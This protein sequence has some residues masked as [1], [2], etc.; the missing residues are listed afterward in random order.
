MYSQ[1]RTAVKRKLKETLTPF[2]YSKWKDM[3]YKLENDVFILFSMKLSFSGLTCTIVTSVNVIPYCTVWD[4]LTESDFNAP[5]HPEHDSF[6]YEMLA[7]L[8]L[9]EFTQENYVAFAEYYLD[10]TTAMCE[11]ELFCNLEEICK[12]I[13]E[14]LMP[15]LQKLTDLEFYY[16]EEVREWLPSPYSPYGKKDIFYL[17][18]KLRKYENALL[19]LDLEIAKSKRNS[20]AKSAELTDLKSRFADGKLTENE[21]LVE[22]LS[23]GFLNGTIN[24]WERAIANWEK[25]ICELQQTKDALLSKNYNFFDS[26]IDKIESDCRKS[27]QSLLK[28]KQAIKRKQTRAWPRARDGGKT[29]AQN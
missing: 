8:M 11:E 29:N 3:F 5:L 9:D 13:K 15:Y 26:H 18:L 6:F 7:R 1:Y 16:S 27:L 20:K 10:L 25:N 14:R 24:D 22:K 4:C 2:G 12:I 23:P 19:Y 17:S 28:G 21:I